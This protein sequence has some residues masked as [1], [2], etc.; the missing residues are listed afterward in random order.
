VNGLHPRSGTTTNKVHKGEG[1]GMKRNA[2][3]I[4][5]ALMLCA[6]VGTMALAKTKMHTINFEQDTTVNGAVVKEGTYQMGFNEQTGEFTI[7]HGNRVIVTTM[8]KE[9]MLG[10]KASATSIGTRLT[11]NGA[12][13]TQITFKGAHYTLLFGDGQEAEGQ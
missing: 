3:I 2:T 12:A 11:D 5:M 9:E 10:Q 1:A 13:L 8:A 4:A 7:L 6:L